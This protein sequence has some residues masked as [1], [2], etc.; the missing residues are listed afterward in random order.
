MKNI[1]ILALAVAL[2]NCSSDTPSGTVSTSVTT[3][4]SPSVI[5]N[6]DPRVA[7]I[8][9]QHEQLLNI[10]KVYV[11]QLSQL[12]GYEKLSAARVKK[13]A[14]QFAGL[15]K[16]SQANL[17]A[18]DQLAPSKAHDPAQVALVGEIAEKQASLLARGEKQLAG[19]HN[20]HY[21]PQ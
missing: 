9:Q 19:I 3:A 2:T 21:L 6:P 11:R 12:K 14:G 17:T 5:T 15:I 8:R 10:Q 20:E 13:S 18:L 4:A 7:I 16:L 1:L